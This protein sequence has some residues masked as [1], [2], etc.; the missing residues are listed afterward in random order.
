MAPIEPADVSTHGRRCLGLITPIARCLPIDARP[1]P[2]GAINSGQASGLVRTVHS[3]PVEVG[4]TEGEHIAIRA[5]QPVPLPVRGGGDP[6]DRRFGR[7]VIA[8]Q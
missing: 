6:D 5:R 7:Y 1:R 2:S 3:K 8:R 4:V